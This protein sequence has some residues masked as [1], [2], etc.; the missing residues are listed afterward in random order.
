MCRP[1]GVRL[2]KEQDALRQI[3][4]LYFGARPEQLQFTQQEKG[5]P[6]MAAATN[7]IHLTFNLSHSGELALLAVA[8]HLQLGVDVECIRSDFGGQ[9]IANRFFSRQEV[10]KLCSLPV[11]LRNQAFFHCWTRKEAYIKAIG[12]GLSK[13]LEDFDV[14]FAPGEDPALLAVRG[15]PDEA[16]RWSFYDLQPGEGYAGALAVEGNSHQIKCWSWQLL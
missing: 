15:D 2:Q 8:L 11:G 14:A 9:E 7:S 5:K 4:A 1:A 6:E 16:S 10:E 13:P 12:E 3:L